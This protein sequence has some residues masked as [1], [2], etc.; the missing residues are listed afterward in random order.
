VGKPSISHVEKKRH[1]IKIATKLEIKK[2][3]GNQGGT[4][5]FAKI[6]FEN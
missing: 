6:F 4:G 5:N 2:Y 1:L 3:Q